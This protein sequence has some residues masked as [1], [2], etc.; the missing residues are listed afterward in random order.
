MEQDEAH[1]PP[2]PSPPPSPGLDHSP[3]IPRR[4]P[5]DS[6]SV[7]EST[8][9]SLVSPKLRSNLMREQ[10]ERDPLFF[11]EVVKTLGVGSMGSVA[12][13]R[14]R[15]HR[16]GG[17][18]RKDIQDA[19]KEQKRKRECFKIPFV[20]GL[21]RLCLDDKLTIRSP[22]RNETFL[23]RTNPAKYLETTGNINHHHQPSSLMLASEDDMAVSST[24]KI[25]SHSSYLGSD[26]CPTN[27]NNMN[28]STRSHG[29]HT[30][31]QSTSVT[32]IEY[33]M[34]SIHLTRITD[35]KFVEE[36]RT[37]IGI[38]KE[39]DH[40]HIIRPIETFEYRQQIFLVMELASGGDL[41]SRDPYTEEQ[42][43]RIISSILSAIGK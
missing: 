28:D 39:L 18:A 22:K 9:T 31:Y 43:A 40:P 15:Q 17:S 42:A 34:K 1:P 16:V 3:K 26:V 24:D 23:D 2:P 32:N 5:F 12:R 21:F 41:Y 8:S 14:K 37:E 13:V 7:R 19:V 20:G 27:H 6:S 29:T 36:L 11:Y 30:S 10:K 35:E 33:A 38:L 25:S 4:Q